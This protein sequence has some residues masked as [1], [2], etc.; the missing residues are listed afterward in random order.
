VSKF[1]SYWRPSYGWVGLAVIVLHFILLPIVEVVCSI[2]QVS[3]DVTI[4]VSAITALLTSVIAIAGMR[5]Y[6]KLKKTDTK[7]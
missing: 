2:M 5:S 1:Q 7:E 3:V 6:D 4:D